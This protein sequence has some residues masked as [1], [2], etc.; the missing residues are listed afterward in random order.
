MKKIPYYILY[1]VTFLLSLL[2]MWAHYLFAD[3]LFLIIYGVARYRRNI[4]EKNLSRSFPE[5]SEKELRHIRR[6]FYHFLCDYIVENV[7]LVTMRKKNVMKRMTFE[8]IDEMKKSLE[9]HDYVFV[10]LGHYGNWEYAASLQW[11]M[12]DD[13]R[14]GQLYSGL[15]NHTFDHWFYKVRTR[16]GGDNIK[17]DEALRH[18]IA[19]RQNRQKVILGFISDQAPKRVN[20]HY[21][22]DFLNQDTPI[23]TGT[24]RIAKKVNAAVYYADVTHPKRGYYNCRFQLLTNNVK[25]FGEF[26]LTAE[27]MHRLEKSIRREPAYWLWSHNRWK[28]QREVN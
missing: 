21:W 13:T 2:P 28:R 11:W 26:E 16:Y 27:Y 22:M 15:R 7:K 24:E 6:R 25:D 8:G 18:I 14:C 9:D 10:Y 3:F 4:V 5:K 20:I 1:S 17:K 23:F 19:Y 12:T